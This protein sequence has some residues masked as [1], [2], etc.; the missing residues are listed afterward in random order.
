MGRSIRPRHADKTSGAL[1]LVLALGLFWASLASGAHADAQEAVP[2][3]AHFDAGSSSSTA[4][5]TTL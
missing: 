5:P 3:K 1:R 2:E 4:W